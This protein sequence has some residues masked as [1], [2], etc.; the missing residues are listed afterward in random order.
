M[1]LGLPIIGKR[2]MSRTMG[3]QLPSSPRPLWE[4]DQ[5]EG[6]GR[7][8]RSMGVFL[9]IALRFLSLVTDICL[10]PFSA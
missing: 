6:C 3:R 8:P 7:R 10:A 5:G 4:R 1:W 9:E 2:D